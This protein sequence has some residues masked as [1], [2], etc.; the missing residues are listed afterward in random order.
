[1]HL[2]LG[3]LVDHLHLNLLKLRVEEQVVIYLFKIFLRLKLAVLVH[4]DHE[5]G[6]VLDYLYLGV[7]VHLSDYR[8]LCDEKQN[9]DV[10]LADF[11][12]S[13]QL[14]AGEPH[15][16]RPGVLYANFVA[17]DQL[18]RI[19][20]RILQHLDD[21]RAAKILISRRDLHQEVCVNDLLLQRLD[22]GR[23][24]CVEHF[25]RQLLLNGRIQ[26]PEVSVVGRLR[27]DLD[28]EQLSQQIAD[29][30]LS[31]PAAIQKRFQV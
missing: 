7:E 30:V 10:R 21:L 4:H 29:N 22:V 23:N 19:K 24:V 25:V 15:Q 12:G 11:F 27:N 31:V 1:M 6:D 20:E 3:D 28:F 18:E 14:E 16:I 13:L 8:L 9:F 5:L 17:V 26:S 2:Y